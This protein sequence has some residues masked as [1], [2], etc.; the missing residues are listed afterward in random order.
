MCVK[1]LT[2]HHLRFISLKGGCTGSSES[3]LVKIPHFWK[4]HALAQLIFIFMTSLFSN[5]LLDRGA[6]LKL[7]ISVIGDFFI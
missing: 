7:R 5:P 3:T 2:E 6:V 1:L 4:S